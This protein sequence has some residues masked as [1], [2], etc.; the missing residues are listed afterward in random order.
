M[1]NK[2]IRTI[3]GV[4][5]VSIFSSGPLLADPPAAAGIVTRDQQPVAL[6]WIDPAAGLRVILG[7]DIDEFCAGIIDFDVIDIQD[8][9]VAEDRV[10][11]NSR[12]QVRT[13]VWDF[14]AFDCALFTT[15]DPVASG[16]STLRNVDN[17]LFG[18]ADPNVNVWSWMAH[19]RL[20]DPYGTQV[21]FSGHLTQLFGPNTDY[22]FQSQIVLH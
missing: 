16:M 9:N 14:L 10:L 15:V 5:A 2:K 4:L 8:V 11:R 6:T 13:T 12:G 18:T 1:N 7:A 21:V 22:R 20:E 19:G 3:M 17:D